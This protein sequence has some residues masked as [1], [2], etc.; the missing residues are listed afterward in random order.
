MITYVITASFTTQLFI[1]FDLTHVF[2]WKHTLV[3]MKYG[4]PE[5]RQ[6]SLHLQLNLKC[7]VG[8]LDVHTASPPGVYSFEDTYC[9][10]GF[11][12]DSAG[13]ESTCNVGDLGSIPGLGRSLW[14][15]KGYPLQ[16]TKSQTQLSDFHFS[17]FSQVGVSLF[18][19]IC[20]WCWHL[21]LRAG[22]GN[23]RQRCLEALLSTQTQFL[24]PPAHQ[25][26]TPRPSPSPN[27]M[28]W[29]HST[30]CPL[31]DV[32]KTNFCL[33]SSVTH[34]V[35]SFLKYTPFLFI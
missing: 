31:G 34:R 17:S 24:S 29:E 19:Q 2:A 27:N 33:T 32:F 11:P 25:A 1:S 18:L 3:N 22:S 10:L 14:E 21:I 12:C 30:G 9:I 23:G 20:M 26:P 28:W 13:K 7:V 8:F 35:N 6:M 16:F 5:F 4:C 15:R